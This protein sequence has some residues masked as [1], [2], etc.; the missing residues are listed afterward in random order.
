M[1]IHLNANPLERERAREKAGQT[2]E[3][4]KKKTGNIIYGNLAYIPFVCVGFIVVACS[5]EKKSKYFGITNESN[6]V[7]GVH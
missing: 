6:R 5:S 7:L 1:C 4:T 2:D 3:I